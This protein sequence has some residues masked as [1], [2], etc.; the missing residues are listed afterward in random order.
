MGKQAPEE[1]ILRDFGYKGEAWRV[2]AHGIAARRFSSSTPGG[3]GRETSIGR[4]TE[5]NDTSAP[6]Q[7]IIVMLCDQL[8]EDRG[9]MVSNPG[10]PFAWRQSA[11]R[12]EVHDGVQAFAR[13]AV[14]RCNAL[15][16]LHPTVHRRVQ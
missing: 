2:A 9:M 10:E 14:D 16:L 15:R 13:G 7:D 5:P 8:I 4:M 6:L 12:Y 11:I 3:T 1:S